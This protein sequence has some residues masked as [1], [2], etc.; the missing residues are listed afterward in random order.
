MGRQRLLPSFLLIYSAVPIY[1]QPM[2]AFWK[3][4]RLPLSKAF[5]AAVLISLASHLLI[6]SLPISGEKPVHRPREGGLMTVVRLTESIPAPR[7]KDDRQE[8]VAAREQPAPKPEA[9]TETTAGEDTAN[10]GSRDGRYRAYLLKIR[11]RIERSWQYPP[12]ALRKKEKGTTTAKFS[13]NKNGSV[14]SP[15]IVSTSGS[16]ILDEY[17]LAVIRTAAPYDRL[18]V[19]LG[20]SKL[21]I[22]AVFHYGVAK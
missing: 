10:L 17:T 5:I 9:T 22:V 4:G 14:S 3:S 12:D 1:D 11:E 20:L 8:P 6:L 19:E 16:Q 15:D 13:I 7:E 18:P 2:K 21:H